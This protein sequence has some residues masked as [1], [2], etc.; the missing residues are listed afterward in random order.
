MDNKLYLL[1]TDMKPMKWTY[2]KTSGTPP[3]KYIQILY[4]YIKMKEPRYG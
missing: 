2:V 4:L 1:K 3:C